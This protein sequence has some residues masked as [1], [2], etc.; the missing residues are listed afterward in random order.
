M[1]RVHI[2][3]WST[4]LL[5]PLLIPD[6]RISRVRL[7]AV[8]SFLKEPSHANRSLSTRL[9]T[10]LVDM[11]ITLTRHAKGV[12]HRYPVLS[13]A[14]SPPQCPLLTE[15][16]FAQRRALPLHRDSV[17]ALSRSALPDL[18]RSYR[19]MRQTK[20]LLPTSVALSSTDLC[21][22][23]RAPAGSWP[24]PTLSLRSLYRCLD[25]YPATTSRC[26]C[27]LLPDGHR[28]LLRVKKIGS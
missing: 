14:V 15:S 1:R 4:F 18:H 13:P 19:P 16:R 17:S 12:Y 5:S 7:A 2:S 21:R 10:P 6:G 27:P 26:V 3:P 24:F 25:P 22:L 9:H 11:V 20:T 23:R 28:P 8:A